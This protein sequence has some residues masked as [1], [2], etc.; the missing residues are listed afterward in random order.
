MQG[1]FSL[2]LSL[3]LFILF[4]LFSRYIRADGQST[5]THIFSPSLLYSHY[6]HQQQQQQLALSHLAMA[7]K[8]LPLDHDLLVACECMWICLCMCVCDAV[9]VLMF[10]FIQT[11]RLHKAREEE[12]KNVSWSILPVAVVNFARSK[13][14]AKG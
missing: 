11:T 8:G 1:Y 14:H 9:D 7:W 3:S 5:H 2:F 10:R 6:H 13:F 12:Y 4:F